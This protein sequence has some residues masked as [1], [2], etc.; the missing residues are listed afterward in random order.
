MLRA[1]VLLLAALAIAP[2]GGGAFSTQSTSIADTMTMRGKPSE[3][4]HGSM[5]SHSPD[6]R[7]M[8]TVAFDESGNEGRGTFKQVARFQLS[9]RAGTAIFRTE[10]GG[11]VGEILW[12]PDSRRVA[13]TVSS[14]GSGGVYDLLLLDRSGTHQLSA[15]FRKAL[16]P[17]M[18]CD[19]LDNS[20]VGAVKWLS[21]SRLLVAAHQ[22]HI[23]SC[24]QKNRVA[25][26][27]YD[28]PS[29]AI[30]ETLE[31]AEVR[32][33]FPGMMGFLID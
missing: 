23:D 25:F 29:A 24:P 4:M 19:L 18:S 14:G 27:I 32:R 10:D 3:L 28:L 22:L 20:N 33:R 31:R 17:P 15:P 1:A 11:Y 12:S 2:A 8:L 5:V 7:S 13:L 30:V 6:G 26:Y 16:N 9:G 21:S